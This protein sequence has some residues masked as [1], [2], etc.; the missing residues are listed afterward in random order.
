VI[1]LSNT[2]LK[3]KYISEII[4]DDYKE[5]KNESVI[6]DAGTASGKTF[7]TLNILAP[8]AAHNKQRMLYLVNRK[9]LLST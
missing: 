8:Y 3:P 6:L 5:W 9:T 2:I 1:H 4:Q 7:F